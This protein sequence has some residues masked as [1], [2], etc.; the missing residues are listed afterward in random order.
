MITRILSNVNAEI[1]FIDWFN[2][3]SSS[4]MYCYVAEAAAAEQNNIGLTVSL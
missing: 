4:I 2:V 1:R 3:K